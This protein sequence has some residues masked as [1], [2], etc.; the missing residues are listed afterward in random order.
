VEVQGEREKITVAFDH[1]L[2]ITLQHQ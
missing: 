1:R 2:S